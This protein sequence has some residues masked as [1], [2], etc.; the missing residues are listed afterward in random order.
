MLVGLGRFCNRKLFLFNL[1]VSN[2]ACCTGSL[3]WEGAG[4]GLVFYAYLG[5]SVCLQL[6]FVAVLIS[7]L[8]V[9][10]MVHEDY[11]LGFSNV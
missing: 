7:L 9:A 2:L 3:E 11:G 1:P 4:V 6:C 8:V 10:E 5:V